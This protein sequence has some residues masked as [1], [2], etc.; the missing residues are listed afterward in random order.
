M[1]SFDFDAIL[2]EYHSEANRR[3]V[4]ALLQD[5]ALVGGGIRELN[6]GTLK[7]VHKRLLKGR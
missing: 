5:F 1:T 7:F 6:R 3:K 4:D 2:L